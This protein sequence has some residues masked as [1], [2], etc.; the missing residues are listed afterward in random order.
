MA[1][2]ASID[3][4]QAAKEA[5]LEMNPAYLLIFGSPQAG[6]PLM[7]RAPT[8]A[9]D[10][11][12]KALVWEDKDGKAWLSYNDPR[13]VAQRHGLSDWGVPKMAPEYE[14][15]AVE[16]MPAMAVAPKGQAKAQ[17]SNPLAS[18]YNALSQIAGDAVRPTTP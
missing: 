7:Q 8:M 12:L 4:A 2:F 16:A 11:P 9:I 14:G 6:T 13:W 1:L 10:L 17:P 3:H 18:M 5:G 15:G